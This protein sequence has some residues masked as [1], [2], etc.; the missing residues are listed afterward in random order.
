M[1]TRP[2]FV[3]RLVPPQSLSWKV[4]TFMAPKVACFS[5]GKDLLNLWQLTENTMHTF[6]VVVRLSNT[7][8]W[9]QICAPHSNYVCMRPKC[10]MLLRIFL[11]FRKR[12]KMW[13]GNLFN[14]YIYF[15]SPQQKWSKVIT[16]QRQKYIH[17]FDLYIFMY[18]HQQKKLNNGNTDLRFSSVKSCCCRSQPSATSRF[19]S[20]PV[21]GVY[22]QLK[23]IRTANSYGIENIVSVRGRHVYTLH[24]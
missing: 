21:F 10:Q 1:T 6:S 17:S 4:F 12:T 9:W 23:L 22:C 20:S 11:R 2:H 5:I 15:A 13:I 24:R 18:H 8:S 3:P 7:N 16:T 19:Y 14:K